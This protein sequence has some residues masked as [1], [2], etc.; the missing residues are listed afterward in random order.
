MDDVPANE[1]STLRTTTRPWV[2]D[3]R[4]RARGYLDRP[5]R[6]GGLL[7]VA[8]RKLKKGDSKFFAL[9]WRQLGA[10]LRLLR[11]YW[12]GAYRDVSRTTLITLLGAVIYFVMPIDAIP[13]WIVGVGFLDDAYVLGIAVKAVKNELDAFLEWE[14][15]GRA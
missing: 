12:K 14:A 4:Q 6:L 8:T 9:F 11:A 10:V 5:E 2:D 13:D 15:A 3:A 1:S 7:D